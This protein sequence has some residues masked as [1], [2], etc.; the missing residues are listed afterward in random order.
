MPA[1]TPALDGVTGLSRLSLT[2]TGQAVSP[3]IHFGSEA[4]LGLYRSG[5]STLA[6]SYGTLNLATQGV[7]L[8]MRTLAASSITVSA[9]ATN[10]AVDEVVLTI[11]GASGASLAVRSGGTVYIFNS[12]LSAAQA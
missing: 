5:V 1:N 6:L 3:A 10:V 9:A 8:S 11:G 12:A 7:R 2:S 4:S